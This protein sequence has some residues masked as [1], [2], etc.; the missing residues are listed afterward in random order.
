MIKSLK[1]VGLCLVL[2]GSVNAED[3]KTFI[4]V[5]AGYV[6]VQGYRLD[7]FNN[8]VNHSDTGA[9][10]GIRIGAQN[11]DWRTTFI[12]NYYNNDSSDQNLEL[13]LFMVD[14]FFMQ[15][16]SNVESK[17]KPYLGLNI[18]YGDY[19]TTGITNINGLLY[20]GEAGVS[21]DVGENMEVDISYRHSLSSTDEFNHIGGVVVGLNYLY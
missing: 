19:E 16:N 17:F 13:G 3:S 21:M 15:G 9:N 7:I 14:Y 8:P 12:Y 11:G 2:L 20:G 6:S 1:A 4:G 10:L 5:E 18:G